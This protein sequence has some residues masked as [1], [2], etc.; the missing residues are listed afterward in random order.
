VLHVQ[1]LGHGLLQVKQ[2]AV[3]GTSLARSMRKTHAILRRA[4]HT[5]AEEEVVR[6]CTLALDSITAYVPPL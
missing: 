4:C 2:A 6:L 5:E 3:Y 1:E